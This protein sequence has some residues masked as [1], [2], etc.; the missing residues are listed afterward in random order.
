MDMETLPCAATIDLTTTKTR[1]PIP[2]ISAGPA[3]ELPGD[4]HL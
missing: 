2:V 3:G 4:R 1:P